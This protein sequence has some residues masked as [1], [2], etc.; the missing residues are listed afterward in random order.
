[1]HVIRIGS[2]STR[3]SRITAGPA[4]YAAGA[5]VRKNLMAVAVAVTLSL[6]I[7]HPISAQDKMGE[8]AFSAINPQSPESA[9]P[10][11]PRAG[12]NLNGPADWNSELPFVDVFHLSR[13][14]VSQREGADWGQG[15]KLQ[16]DRRGYVTKLEPNCFAETPMNTVSR[17]P[18]GRYTVL[19]KGT[20]QLDAGGNARKV[21]ES[22]GHMI[23]EADGKGSIFLRLLKTDPNDYV[24]DI[25]VI[26]PG[27]E[28]TYAREPFHPIFLQRWRGMTTLR[29]MDWMQTNNSP[30]QKWA[31]RPTMD[32]AT[33]TT[34]GGIPIEMMVELS[35]RLGADPWFCMPHRAND[36]YV[37]RFAEL[38]KERLDPKRRIYVEFSN[39]VWNGMF[40]QARWSGQRGID[41]GIATPEGGGEPKP[42]VGQWHYTARRSVEIFKIWDEVFGGREAAARRLVRVL[43][44]QAGNTYVAEQILKFEDAAKNADALAIAPY[45]S[46]NISEQGEE[47]TAAGVANWSA[48]QVLDYLEQKSLPESLQWVADHKRLADRH[49]LQ[50]IAYEAGQ[51]AVGIQGGENNDALT[52]LL[53]AVNRHPR[54]GEIYTAYL[55]GWQQ[56]GGGLICLFASTGG[57]SKWGSWGLL[58]NYDD[59]AAAYPKF[60]ATMKW[61]A[62]QGQPVSIER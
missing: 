16:L 4:R 49:G 7:S 15:P 41:L 60:E 12:I 52:A 29:F 33:W 34:E 14:W 17:S 36:D 30:Q 54:M 1:M 19:Y 9:A 18:A 28:E 37:R 61:A 13:T 10:G 57:W 35:N 45:V 20:G 31:D 56:N 21:S 2:Y 11:L 53:H 51:H 62:S 59:K 25:R 32:D 43:A 48:D 40:E 23:I 8:I 58:E 46:F 26:M 39:E 50:L 44:S 3:T 5:C 42:W 47:L 38:V 24:R 27:F 22:P 6:T 55:K